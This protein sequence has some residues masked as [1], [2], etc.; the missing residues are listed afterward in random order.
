MFDFNFYSSLLLIGFVQGLVYACL[1]LLRG[2]RQDRISDFFAASILLVGALY[3][4]PW[5]LGF[6][7]WYDAHDWRTTLMFYGS[8]NNLSLLGPL[9]WLYFRSATNTDFTWRRRYWWHFL[10]FALF[11]LLPLGILLYDWLYWWLWLGED[12]TFFYGTRGPAAEWDNENGSKLYSTFAYLS[13]RIMTII[14]LGLVVMDYRRYRRYVREQFSNSGHL[15][16][17][18]LSYLLL[19]LLGSISITFVLE[20]ITVL[21]DSPSY[22][23]EWKRF[24]SM[25]ILVF[26]AA[27]QFYDIDPRLTRVLRFAPDDPEEEA[28][29]A[30]A[31]PETE[32]GGNDAA[33]LQ[34]IAARLERRLEVHADYLDPEVKLAALAERIGT[35]SSVLSRVINT[36][37][38]MN[39]NDYIN[40]RR[41]SAFIAKLAAG[42]HQQHTLLS[43]ALDCGFNSKSTFNRAFRKQY[44]YSP[45]EAIAKIDATPLPHEGFGQ[46]IGGKS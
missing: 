43:L 32:R 19:L 31:T 14:Y 41:C 33:E 13:I 20:A 16:L 46:A 21:T 7:G 35:N 18:G 24:F 23:D 36:T 30:T 25:S 38:A 8:W 17:S 4:A 45:R 6:A 44:G 15:Q 37:Y 1:L 22:V 5:M 11:S 3:V 40:A 2:L 39:F 42:E 12:F 26:L 28:R 9:V 27:I 10:P 34:R 29:S